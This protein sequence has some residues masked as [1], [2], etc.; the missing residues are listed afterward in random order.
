L[1]ELALE[2]EAEAVGL[3]PGS[4]LSER[5]AGHPHPDLTVV[6]II[7][8]AVDVVLEGY[9]RDQSRAANLGRIINLLGVTVIDAG[10]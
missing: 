6:L 8:A 7:A 10:P 3:H 4:Q 1:G 2:N 9:S 5:A